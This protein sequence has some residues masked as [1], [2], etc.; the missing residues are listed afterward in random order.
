VGGWSPWVRWG[1]VL[2][3]RLRVASGGGFA[4]SR[5]AFLPTH[6]T[7]RLG[8]FGYK[9]PPPAARGSRAPA[10][11][12]PACRP[13]AF[14]RQACRRQAFLALRPFRPLALRPYGRRRGGAGGSGHPVPVL[15]P[16]GFG[17][18]PPPAS[19]ISLRHPA[20]LPAQPPTPGPAPSRGPPGARGPNRPPRGTGECVAKRPGSAAPGGHGLPGGRG[21]SVRRG[22]RC[23]TAGGR[24]SGRVATPL[25]RRVRPARA[26]T[27]GVAWCGVGG[28]GGA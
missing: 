17:L 23:E 2:F 28:R 12:P 6:P 26:G 5:R 11:R 15:C 16:Q 21:L 27:G 22:V 9:T 25:V 14:R 10:C 18:R 19:G 1:C 7:R 3:W 20:R 4:A 8:R 13:P 24:C